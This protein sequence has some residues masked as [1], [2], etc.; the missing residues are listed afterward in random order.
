LQRTIND[1]YHFFI[2]QDKN[3]KKDN[4]YLVLGVK[5]KSFSLL[6]N[7]KFYMKKFT[8]LLVLSALFSLQVF[9]QVTG[10][11]TDEVTGE[12]IPGANVLV[13]G[14]TV[15]TITNLD[16]VYS[17]TLPEGSDEL[18]ISFVGMQNA[19]VTVAGRTVVNVALKS[20][21][22]E[23]EEVV[24]TALGVKKNEK[25]L[26]YSSTK[27]GNDDL[28]EG[29]V[30][31][32]MN[33][34]QGKVAGVNITSGS[35]APGS[36]TR[37]ILRGFTSINGDNQPL[38][39]VDGIPI[40]NRSHSND[41]LND[42]TDFGNG[43]NDINPDDI[44][45]MNIMK[46]SAGSALY[47]SRA[48]N[49]VIIITTKKGK[50][51]GAKEGL[52][53][54]YTGTAT[55]DTPLRLPQYQNIFGQG[56]GGAWDLRE[57]TSYGPRMDGAMRYWGYTV[58]GE[59][60]IKPY[61]P[62]E[63]NVKDF[64][65]IGKTY[66]HSVSLSGGDEKVSYFS[67]YSYVDADGIWPTDADSYKRHTFSLRGNANFS[68]K[69][70]SSASVNYA[71][72]T[73]SSVSSGQEQAVF[74]NI[75]QT[76][77]DIPLLELAD[78]KN[79]FFNNDNY[80]GN[81]TTN[82]YWILNE[83]GNLNNDDHVYG[84]GELSYKF[85]EFFNALFR[86][87]MDVSNSQTKYWR[88]IKIN[89]GYNAGNSQNESGRVKD[90]KEM[91]SQLTT[92]FILTF[93]KAFGDFNF[94]ALAGHNF[95]KDVYKYS[96]A[97][98]LTLDVPNFYQINNSSSV[99]EVVDYNSKRQLVGVY[100]QASVNYKYF[101]VEGT[102]RNDWSSTLPLKNNSF[103]YYSGSGSFVFTE[104]FPAIQKFLTFGKIRGSYTKTGKDASVYVINPVFISG[105]M[106]DGFT[107]Y[108][109][110]VNDVN[111]YEVSGTIGNPELTPEFTY[112][113]ELGTDMRFFKNRVSIDFS[114]YKK[115]SVHQIIRQ[116]QPASTGYLYQYTN[117]G[118]IE[119]KGFE[120]LLSVKP[121][122]KKNFSWEVTATYSINRNKVLDL[123][124]NL[125]ELPWG[126]LSTVSFD[127]VEGYSMGVFRGPAPLT[128]G[129]G[130]IVVNSQGFPQNAPYNS[131]YGTG[132]YDYMASLT[133]KFSYKG[134]SLNTLLDIRQGGLMYSRT[135]S[136]VY[137]SGNSVNTL[138]NMREP[139][140]IPNSVK[141]VGTVENPVYVDND[142]PVVS[143]AIGGSPETYWGYGG[144]TGE[145]SS[146]ISKSFVKL[147]ELSLNYIIPKR[148]VERIHITGATVSLVGRNLLIWT[149][150][151][152]RFI[153]PEVTTFG[154][155]ALADYGEFSGTPA[156]KSIGFS[157]QLSF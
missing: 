59:R 58:D 10:T 128:D 44:E 56:I 61:S 127:I 53:I 1:K 107:N 152:N 21:A 91:M 126:G 34:L 95:N 103:L 93:N 151:E 67:S 156:V 4:F 137:F 75:L 117:I 78:Y 30:S 124:E 101:Y 84:S 29:R 104:A 72:K 57:N 47:G 62:L 36:S 71:K 51:K 146:V 68:D 99:P 37:V 98:V 147:R 110:P 45:S 52:D 108:N 33:A 43:I 119:N 134:L 35:G 12:P 121:I 32:A 145:R 120:V 15:G 106:S 92:D 40:N 20:E 141:N 140:I 138:Y 65:D 109:L 142:I 129:Q 11:V 28:T 14:T 8:F 143:S 50:N 89:G 122:E 150:E 23:V 94:N 97:E 69:F 112:E 2:L 149:P 13:K 85:N 70:S 42:G 82:P 48:S 31:S 18:V 90:E 114:I 157:V 105:S 64:F 115:N 148:I 123:G 46:G 132:E 118:N 54:K 102:L 25:A 100:G 155:N 135:A 26:G 60:L 125:T 139:F 5:K 79:K 77:R 6:T 96:S 3:C 76:S 74:D 24:V 7:I 27:V 83:N 136:I 133:N 113:S 73:N 55:F 144:L 88:A 111:G 22:T 19:E 81:Y 86:T 87:G 130:H 9:S 80:F 153:D 16:G 17:I 154:N 39:V 66:N 41:D 63:N 49:G 116:Q 131:V 38:Y